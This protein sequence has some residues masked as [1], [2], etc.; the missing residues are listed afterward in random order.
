MKALIAE[1]FTRFGARKGRPL[2]PGWTTP[3]V[4]P[5]PA[6]NVGVARAARIAKT[7]SADAAAKSLSALTPPTKLGSL[8]SPD[9]VSALNERIERFKQRVAALD[10][11]KESGKDNV[12]K[13][14]KR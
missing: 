12:K 11:F 5:D 3:A 4:K 6:P 14:P 10:R 9:Y 1:V 13:R 8:A 2:E 7:A